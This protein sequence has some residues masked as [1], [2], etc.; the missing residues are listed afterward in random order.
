MDLAENDGVTGDQE[1]QCRE[2]AEKGHARRAVLIEE[3]DH[4][5]REIVD[6]RNRRQH[7]IPIHL[8][9]PTVQ[10]IGQHSWKM[11]HTIIAK[12]TLM[13]QV[14]FFLFRQQFR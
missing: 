3:D 9:N 6:L 10:P 8:P 7:A 11:S 1:R 12:A 13:P 5:A 4:R 14:N 2:V